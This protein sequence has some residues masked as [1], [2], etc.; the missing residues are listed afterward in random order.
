MRIRFLFTS[1][2]FLSVLLICSCG[3]KPVVSSNN[4]VT[5]QI[6][7]SVP[8]FNSISVDDDIDVAFVIGECAVSVYSADNV[9]DYIAVKV[10]NET[11]RVGYA[12]DV[13]VVGDD[14]TTVYVAAP[15]LCAVTHNGSGDVTLTGATANAVYTVNGSGD[16]DAD[17]MMADTLTVTVNGSGDVDCYARNLL[18]ANR[19][20]RGEINYEGAPT[21]Q[22]QAN[23]RGIER[24][25]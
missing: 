19:T 23:G 10:E 14:N 13:V 4:Y 20:G 1:V 8:C 22:V 17:E 2:M 5:K 15:Q 11:L 25:N 18:I 24:D 6:T 3:K 12:P 16:L 21:L 7:E 9:V